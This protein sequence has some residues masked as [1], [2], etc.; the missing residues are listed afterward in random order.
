MKAPQIKDGILTLGLG[1]ESLGR[2]TEY[3]V[4]VKELKG[5]NLLGTGSMDASGLATKRLQVVTAG[6]GDL[7][8]AGAVDVLDLTVN[9]AGSFLGAGLSA[10]TASIQHTGFG[11]ATVRVAQCLDA[12][13][14]G[15]GSV[16]YLG[17]PVVRRNIIGIGSVR[18]KR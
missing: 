11:N 16:E 17:N 15:I 5:L 7:K 9:G 3:V 10:K 14:S 2:N 4:E 8:A 12:T 1:E 18:P 13:L 6:S